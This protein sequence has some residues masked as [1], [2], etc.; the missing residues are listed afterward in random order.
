MQIT[1]HI[2]GMLL[3]P[4]ALL[5]SGCSTLSLKEFA[6]TEGAPKTAFVDIKQRGVFASKRKPDGATEYDLIM[7]A[8]PSPD[9]LSSIATEFAADAKY[10]DALTATL[11]FSQQE[12][13]SFVGLRTQT[14]QLLRDGMYRLCEGYLSGALT[15]SDF[16]WLSRRYQRNMVALLTIEQ[17]TRVAQVPAIG[18][19]SQAMAA[20]SRSAAAIQGDLEELDKD[21]TRLAD[22]KTKIDAE[23][24]EAEKLPD[25]DDKKE[26]IAAIDKRLA[27]NAAATK[28]VGEIRAALLEGLSSAKGVLV[29]G[30]TAVQVLANNV[31]T[32]N[33][34]S[35]VVANRIANIAEKVLDQDDLPT[36]C[37]QVLDGSRKVT[38]TDPKLAEYCVQ[39][40]AA[41]ASFEAQRAQLLKQL[42]L[43]KLLQEMRA[44]APTSSDTANK[45]D[46]DAAKDKAKD[47]FSTLEELIRQIGGPGGNP[48]ASHEGP[49]P[50]S[51]Q[52]PTSEDPTKLPS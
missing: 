2:L 31:D 7:C 13:A 42:D 30:S 11:G 50:P 15:K 19:V 6:P 34:V 27:D 8:E 9:A 21:L 1:R 18:Q 10:K 46:K 49:P 32:R 45:G 20:A 35:D 3:A 23:K 5:I 24:T 52:P 40:I 16:A 25:G 36:L 43:Q 28:R 38:S 44:A 48:L 39:S 37:F 51:V 29:N 26:K 12:A 17:L 47:Q 14:I 4:A 22:E 41:R 33:Q